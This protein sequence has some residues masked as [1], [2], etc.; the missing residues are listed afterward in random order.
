PPAPLPP[1]S[2]GGGGLPPLAWLSLT[3]QFVRLNCP[4]RL[5]IAAP[6]PRPPLSA[7]VAPVPPSTE[8]LVN[9]QSRRTTVPPRLSR[10]APRPSPPAPVTGLDPVWKPSA[11]VR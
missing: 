3:M 9:T 8:W 1:I 4:P 2:A 11:T 5:K 7:N 10:P 6:R